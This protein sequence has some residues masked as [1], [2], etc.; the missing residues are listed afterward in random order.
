MARTFTASLEAFRDL[1]MQN[2]RYVATEAIQDVL[3]AA[4]TPQPSVTRTGTF[5]TGKIPVDT[6]ELINSLSVEGATGPD[7]YVTA[8]AG[9]EIGDVLQFE[10][11]A[12][13]ALPMETGFTAVN[14]TQVP[15]RHF[16]GQNAARFS[17]FVDARAAEVKS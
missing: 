13:H 17:E 14:G 8:I 7:A 11:T 9:L 5:E 4:Q 10:W 3:E 6:S 1:T 15:G 2:M 12:P 16:V